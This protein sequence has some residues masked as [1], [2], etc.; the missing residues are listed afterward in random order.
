MTEGYISRDTIV[1]HEA[2]N[3]VRQYIIDSG[4]ETSTQGSLPKLSTYSLVKD[5][6]RLMFTEIPRILGQSSKGLRHLVIYKG[7]NGVN[8]LKNE[9]VEIDGRD[10]V[11]GVG[12]TIDNMIP[13]YIINFDAGTIIGRNGKVE[14]SVNIVVNPIDN[15]KTNLSDPEI[16]HKVENGQLFIEI[17]TEDGFYKITQRLHIEGNLL[18]HVK[19]ITST[20]NNNENPHYM[21]PT[22]IEF[23]PKEAN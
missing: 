3:E 4:F 19:T 15:T 6:Q 21:M 5:N 2:L 11:S 10:R 17:P 18:N 8:I 14:E 23:F 12:L 9:S 1:T 7:Q 16:Q 20:M 13:G 22:L